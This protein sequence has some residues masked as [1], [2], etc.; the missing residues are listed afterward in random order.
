MSRSS[1]YIGP[2]QLRVR[3]D[4][5]SVRP[6][7]PPP[8][9]DVPICRH[10]I[11]RTSSHRCTGW[12]VRAPRPTLGAMRAAA[13]TQEVIGD[14]AVG[15]V[16]DV[17]RQDAR[18][19]RHTAHRPHERAILRPIRVVRPRYDTDGDAPMDHRQWLEALGGLG[20]LRGWRGLTA[21]LN[22]ENL[23]GSLDLTRAVHER[24]HRT[25]SV[26]HAYHSIAP[27]C[28]G[29]RGRAAHTLS[30]SAR[31]PAVPRAAEK[32]RQGI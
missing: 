6:R 2:E 10:T 22:L 28:G 15:G 31:S 29:T 7:V 1:L 8:T 23:N 30:P 18:P 3:L 17:E 20:G 27:Y 5:R 4:N 21:V 9:G 13:Q 25:A 19:D 26:I 14:T 11:G 12:P 16:W 24:L 32:R